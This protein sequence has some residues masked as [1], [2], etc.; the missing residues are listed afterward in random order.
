MP[1]DRVLTLYLIGILFYTQIVLLYNLFYRSH[2]GI[3]YNLYR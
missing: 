1:M 3:E 2:V